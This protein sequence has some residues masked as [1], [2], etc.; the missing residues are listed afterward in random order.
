MRNQIKLQFQY[1]WYV[2]VHR[3]FFSNNFLFALNGGPG[4][5]GLGL[6][7]II[8]QLIPVKYG[9][10]IIVPDHRGTGFSTP[11]GC[12]DQNS[13]DVT[14]DCI[15]YLT[16]RWTI[17]GL[18]QFSTT[19]AAHDLAIQIQAAQLTGRISILGVSYGTY[20][21]NRFLTIYPNLVQAAVMDSPVHPRLHSF[22]MYN[23]RASSMALQFLTYCHYQIECIQYFP[24]S[25]PIIM[26][27]QILQEMDFKK[28]KCINTYLSKYNLT[29]QIIKKFF[30]P[31]FNQHRIIMIELQFQQLY[32]ELIVVIKM[33]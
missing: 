25:S 13:Q 18:Q 3:I 28:Q 1:L 17:N 26:L 12:D 15:T 23:I 21:L 9:L 2:S 11:L 30:F 31:C 29:S 7:P 32:I 27:Y 33:M 19:S 22:S 14:M 24:N 5:A 10:T 8:I 20:W 6:L 16:N 4:E